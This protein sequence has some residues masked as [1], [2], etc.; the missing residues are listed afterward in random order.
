[1]VAVV[2]RWDV[3]GRPWRRLRWFA[4]VMVGSLVA[5]AGAQMANAGSGPLVATDQGPKR[6]PKHF[7]VHQPGVTYRFTSLRW[8]RWG[9]SRPAARGMLTQCSNMERCERLGRAK[10][11]LR[12]RRPARCEGIRGRFY[13]RGTIT[14]EGRKTPLDLDPSYVC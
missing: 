8:K 5:V 11:R 7:S 6:H 3:D 9:R 14:F 2:R 4:L 10:L 1:M 13:V 12:G